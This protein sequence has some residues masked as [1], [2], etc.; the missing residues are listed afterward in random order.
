[1]VLSV[2]GYCGICS[3]LLVRG[4]SSFRDR[5]SVH[6]FRQWWPW[7]F[8]WL[9]TCKEMWS[10]SKNHQVQNGNR[11]K[12]KTDRWGNFYT[13]TSDAHTPHQQ[14]FSLLTVGQ[15]WRCLP[16]QGQSAWRL[17]CRWCG[18]GL[19][20]AWRCAPPGSSLE[21]PDHR[22]VGA[23]SWKREVFTHLH[24][25][26]LYNVAFL[27][28]VPV[29]VCQNILFSHV[30]YIQL[31]FTYRAVATAEVTEVLNFFNKWKFT[32]YNEKHLHGVHFVGRLK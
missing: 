27:L 22:M 13:T 26:F 12:P 5:L 4:C 24:V 32:F 28:M 16:S 25:I 2:C 3:S 30:L 21:S 19:Q 10:S 15:G 31:W 11:L 9:F 1:M 6:W 7:W 18:G 20:W 14:V 29:R 23:K 17:W 8:L